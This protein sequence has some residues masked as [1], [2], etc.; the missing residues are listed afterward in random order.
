MHPRFEPFC[1][2]VT[3]GAGGAGL[4]AGAVFCTMFWGGGSATAARGAAASSCAVSAMD[5]A[6]PTAEP[7][8]GPAV[9]KGAG[10]AGLRAVAVFW[11][12]QP[13]G[14]REHRDHVPCP[15]CAAVLCG[16][17]S[18]GPRRL[19]AG[20]RRGARGSRR[21]AG[22]QQRGAAPALPRPW[23]RRPR[24]RSRTGAREWSSRWWASV[25]TRP[26]AGDL[27]RRAIRWLVRRAEATLAGPRPGGALSACSLVPAIARHTSLSL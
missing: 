17:S 3:K 27:Q 14:R 21:G 23:R 22:A 18:G 1:P 26:R 4:R 16:H 15:L 25:R 6:E 2:A 7:T 20:G 8:Q 9:T 11:G 19:R 5:G 10:G 13:A 12:A 24:S